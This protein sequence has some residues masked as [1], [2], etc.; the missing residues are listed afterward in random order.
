MFWLCFVCCFHVCE[1]LLQTYLSKFTTV[2]QHSA[3]N[4]KNPKIL[5]LGARYERKQMNQT[6]WKWLRVEQWT[7]ESNLKSYLEIEWKCFADSTN[8]KIQRKYPTKNTNAQRSIV[9]KQL[10]FFVWKLY[11]N[12]RLWIADC[13]YQFACWPK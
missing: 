11:N 1:F 9:A 6:K 4:W 3:L 8:R 12:C 5:V 2:Y 7:V 10:Y 13:R